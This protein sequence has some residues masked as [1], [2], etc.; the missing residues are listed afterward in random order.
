M[1]RLRV[2][3]ALRHRVTRS[4]DIRLLPGSTVLDWGER[5]VNS[6]I[7][8]R[9]GPYEV[10]TAD[11]SV[12]TVHVRESEEG[13]RRPYNSVQVRHYVSETD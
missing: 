11:Y 1:A 4:A 12:K 8:E 6:R 10:V 3:I 5:I 7:G 9:I 13:L 2:N